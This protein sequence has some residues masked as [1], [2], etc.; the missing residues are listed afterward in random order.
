M[1]TLHY[2]GASRVL[3]VALVSC[4]LAFTTVLAS[5]LS[6]HAATISD[7]DIS[8]QETV[9]RGEARETIEAYV[10]LLLYSIIQRLEMRVDA[11]S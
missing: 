5:P 1:R 8:T 4:I 11:Q 3:L 7:A 2:N 6:A 10:R 9:V